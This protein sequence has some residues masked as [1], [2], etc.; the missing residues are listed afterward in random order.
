VPTHRPYGNKHRPGYC[1]DAGVSPLGILHGKT[2]GGLGWRAMNDRR[3]NQI[4]G[5]LARTGSYA[6]CTNEYGVMDMV[7][8]LHEWTAESSGTFRGGYYLDTQ[9]LGR[10][11]DY[12]ADGHDRH[13]RDYSTGF[14]C[15]SDFAG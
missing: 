15:C 7:G 12:A 10:G 2:L 1:N 9:L 11:C 4:P 5:S 13:Y 6:R 8:N 14:R 3:L